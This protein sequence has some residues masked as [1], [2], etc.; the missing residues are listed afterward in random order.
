MTPRNV[1]SITTCQ[2]LLLVYYT[3]Y[4]IDLSVEVQNRSLEELAVSPSPKGEGLG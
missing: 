1:K 4:Q 2:Y 3:L